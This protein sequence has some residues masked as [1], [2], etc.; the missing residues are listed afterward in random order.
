MEELAHQGQMTLARKMAKFEADKTREK[1]K[2]AAVEKAFQANEREIELLRQ[3]R[4]HIREEKMAQQDCEIFLEVGESR[5]GAKEA[6][7]RNESKRIWS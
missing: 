1:A 7:K 3:E 4:E 2:T 6:C 5:S